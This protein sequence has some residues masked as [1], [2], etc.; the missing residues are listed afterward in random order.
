M[1]KRKL[2]IMTS[3]Q[4][5]RLNQ[6]A[7]ETAKAIDTE[8]VDDPTWNACTE[9]QLAVVQGMI[10]VAIGETLVRHGPASSPDYYHEAL[11]RANERAQRKDEDDGGGVLV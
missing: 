5:D 4:L 7:Y 3:T 6:L 9:E 1:A 8:L 2:L 11:A 10:L